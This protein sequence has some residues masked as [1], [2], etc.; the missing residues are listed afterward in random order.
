MEQDTDDSNVG[1]WDLEPDEDAQGTAMT[2]MHEE[3]QSDE[4]TGIAQ[5]P[6]TAPASDESVQFAKIPT[7]TAFTPHEAPQP[8]RLPPKNA[9]RPS[10]PGSLPPAVMPPRSAMIGTPAPPG[11]APALPPMRPPSGTAPV[12]GNQAFSPQGPPVVV[13]GGPP[14]PRPAELQTT[15]PMLA[16]LK[17]ATPSTAAPPPKPS[18]PPSVQQ[19]PQPPTAQ[20]P[21]MFASTPPPSVP[22]P[23]HA[24]SS[25]GAG[26]AS[27][28]LSGVAPPNANPPQPSTLMG[29]QPVPG[30][31][32]PPT[33]PS[34]A[35]PASGYTP[36]PGP[37]QG[38]GNPFHVVRS[39]AYSFTLDAR[40]LPVELG[41]GR[42]AKAYLGEER[43]L[44][45]KTDFRREIVIKILQKGVSDEDH[46]RFQMEKELLERVQGHPNVVEL[47]ASGEGDDSFLPPSIRDKV[48]PEFMIL[49]RLE[50]SLEERLKGSRSKGQ[51]DD[52]LAANMT[53]RVFRVLDY[54]IP[55]ASAIEYAHLV[56][57]I[58][59]RDL[60]PANVLVKLPDPNLRG[61]ALQVRLADFNVAKLNDEEVNFGMTQMRTAVPGTLFFQSPEQETNIIE[62]LVNVQQGSPEV[63]YFE[64]FYIQIAKNDSFSLFNRGEQYAVVYADRAR[65][66]LVLAK[67][68]RD[69]TETNVR[70][71]IQKAVGRPAD[72]YSL[73]AMLYYLISGAYANP[74]TLYDAFHK[75]VEYEKADENNTIESYLQH[76]YGVIQSLRTPRQDGTEVA[77][78]DRFFSYKHYLDGN[79]DL[80]D[81]NIMLVI[82]KCMIRNKPDS[83]CQPHDLET[84]GI[85]DL[86]QDL[87]GLY[88][89]YGMHASA[90]PTNLVARGN[91]R[92]NLLK[93][94]LDRVGEGFRR[95]L[96]A[97]RRLFSRSR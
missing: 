71:R 25:F 22:P 44:E 3:F 41:S 30:P 76:E 60:K 49:E 14:P 29:F 35:P 42:F 94:R 12:L 24:M 65:K 92:R 32:G 27:G 90:R 72:I 15:S 11:V 17:V 77:P 86:V 50:M 59:H 67:P 66:R 52:L 55:I 54:V 34:F 18:V 79:G 83:Y 13:T 84:R 2:P 88:S 62:L 69:V 53:E 63:E 81:G 6:T 91:V 26:S 38:A 45:S 89:V 85:S 78:A 37:V 40:G 16:P 96:H 58:C 31:Q 87:I 80:I 70:A 97:V 20:A 10:N 51:K 95:I 46:M 4:R 74:K 57:N 39:R 9:P 1:T 61:S 36:S 43:W 64:D 28:P 48:E 19:A 75:F 56:R 33:G 93:M 68:Y 73:G 23:P 8:S 82:A 21:S 7:P 47:L 5:S